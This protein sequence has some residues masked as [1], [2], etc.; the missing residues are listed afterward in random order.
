[1]RI[2]QADVTDATWCGYFHPTVGA[3]PGR[4]QKRR[5]NGQ[6]SK[7]WLPKYLAHRLTLVA[8]RANTGVKLAAMAGSDSG[9]GRARSVGGKK[10]EP[11]VFDDERRTI[12]PFLVAATIMV[13]VL[14]AIVLMQVLRP[15][16][17]RLTDQAKVTRVVN[18]YYTAQN[19][20]NYT[21][22]RAV[23]CSA[24]LNSADFPTQEAF[25]N[26]NRDARDAD[27]KIEVSNISE[28]VVNG[29]RATAN[30]HWFREHKSETKIT[31]I[32]LVNE[33]GNWKVCA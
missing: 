4:N 8:A 13:V 12:W 33:D 14:I 16:E 15:A 6:S 17:E 32:V 21:S 25:T 31:P 9:A 22:Y 11:E 3:G 10:T 26:E 24:E 2:V 5:F 27:G 29:D 19:A 20:I 18:D 1:M 23:F 28:T 30:V 7:V